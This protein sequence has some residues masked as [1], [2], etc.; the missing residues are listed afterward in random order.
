MSSR[1]KAARAT[2]PDWAVTEGSPS[3]D[4]KNRKKSHDL[5][6]DL[7]F[8]WITDPLAESRVKPQNLPRTEVT[9]TPLYR[10]PTAAFQIAV[11][12]G[13]IK[14]CLSARGKLAHDMS[15]NVLSSWGSYEQQR[16]LAVCHDAP[17][18]RVILRESEWTT[19]TGASKAV[20]LRGGRSK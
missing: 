4:E 11:S 6:D 14:S 7:F 8:A 9:T 3:Y 5:F 20:R 10:T 2:Q 12:R 18:A 16:R 19:V 17:L 13:A 15:G 1:A